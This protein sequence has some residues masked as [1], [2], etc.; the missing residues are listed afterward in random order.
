MITLIYKLCLSA[1]DSYFVAACLHA[2]AND[3]NETMIARMS[4][5]LSPSG[6][7]QASTDRQVNVSGCVRDRMEDAGWMQ[8]RV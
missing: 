2:E 3:L 8:R 7:H 1:T 6:L 4:K 5:C